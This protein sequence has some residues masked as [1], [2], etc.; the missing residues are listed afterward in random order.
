MRRSRDLA[1]AVQRSTGCSRSCK[2][3][4]A[5][6]DESKFL[7]ALSFL[8]SPAASTPCP[9]SIHAGAPTVP[10]IGWL[11]AL[12]SL[13]NPSSPRAHHSTPRCVS[14]SPPP[15]PF[16][17]LS[18]ESKLSRPKLTGI[19]ARRELLYSRAERSALEKRLCWSSCGN[20][21]RSS[22]RAQL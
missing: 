5:C 12:Q 20:Y 22:I 2:R 9:C 1:Q 11:G 6:P 4:S 21:R 15:T 7:V 18:E 19:S 14:S 16:F 10:C 17:P 3:R 8:N 13:H